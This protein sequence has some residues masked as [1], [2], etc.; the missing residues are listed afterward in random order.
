MT[1]NSHPSAQDAEQALS[2]V[3]MI[4][5]RAARSARRAARRYLLMTGAALTVAVIGSGLIIQS[6]GAEA[7]WPRALVIGVL[8][9]VVFGSALA[10]VNAR[11]VRAA[12]ARRP[13]VV[14]AAASALVVGATMAVGP[15]APLLYPIGA[16]AVAAVWVVGAVL[17]TR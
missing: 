8:W 17:A 3:D 4:G 9:A 2:R 13:T 15:D 7:V 12:P 5:T 1:D 11:A 14:T 10:L 6:T 16:A